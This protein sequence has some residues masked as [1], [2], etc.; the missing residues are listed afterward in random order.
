L[1][2]TDEQQA[3]LPTDEDV[4]RYQERGWYISPKILSDDVVDEAVRGAKQHWEGHRDW[5]LPITEGFTD[6]RPGDPE[7]VRIGEIIALQNHAIRTL[8]QQPIISAVAARL[9]GTSGIRLWESELIQKPPQ[10]IVADAA[11]GWHTDRAYWMTCTSERMLTAWI[12]F[13]DC[14]IEMGPLMV[15]EGSHRWA[16]DHDALRTFKDVD[17]ATMEQQL[18]DGRADARKVS[19]V[20]EKGQVSFHNSLLLHG[21]DV[22]RSDQPR[23]CLALHLQDEE[24]R[25]R[26]YYNAA[27]ELWKVVADRLCATDEHGDPDYS[28]PAVCP[29]FWTQD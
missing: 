16:L 4:A 15:V 23:L 25:Y 14:P 1:Q 6:W 7:T 18:T 26:R 5:Q 2:L 10:T 28:D 24:N 12:P 20:L 8:A 11:I 19:M 27:G 9:A 21:S 17:L 29:T 22:N 13:H 3:L